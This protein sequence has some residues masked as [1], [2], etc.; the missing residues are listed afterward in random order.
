MKTWKRFLQDWEQNQGCLFFL[1]LFDIM[2][3]VL[4]KLDKKKKWNLSKSEMKK[5]NHVFLQMIYI[6]TLKTPPQN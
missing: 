3:Q 2:L 4:E 6:E 5:K 1:L